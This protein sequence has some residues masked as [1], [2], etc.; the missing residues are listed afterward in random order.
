MSSKMQITRSKA[1]IEALVRDNAAYRED[2]DFIQETISKDQIFIGHL[3]QKS[4]A[5]NE[6]SVALTVG[7]YRRNLPE[8]IFSGVPSNVVQN[9]V[10][11]LSEGLDFDREFLRSERLKQIL[12]FD[13]MA[14]PID[15]PNS[16]EVM[17]VCRDYYTLIGR[18]EMQA[19]QLV[20]ADENGS[21][22]WS[23][24]CSDANKACQPLFG[25]TA[26]F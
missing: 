10:A 17:Q 26:G 18:H 3:T 1:E 15:D 19:V 8:L 16:L 11:A 20:F 24:D 9:I 13:V 12:N 7:M 5:G 25:V 4:P 14:L 21:F 2:I 22:P 23:P 6:V